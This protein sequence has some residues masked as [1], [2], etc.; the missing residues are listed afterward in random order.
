MKGKGFVKIQETLFKMEVVSPKGGALTR[1]PLL[2]ACLADER[3]Q[4]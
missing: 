1:E 3:R 4:E 2:A